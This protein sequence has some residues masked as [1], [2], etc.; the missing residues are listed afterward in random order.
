MVV[1]TCRVPFINVS[2]KFDSYKFR[3]HRIQSKISTT[4]VRGDLGATGGQEKSH[5]IGFGVIAQ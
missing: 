2:V 5:S 3:L 1:E 4:G